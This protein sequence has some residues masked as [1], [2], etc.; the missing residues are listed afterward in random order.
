M[1][2]QAEFIVRHLISLM[3][4]AQRGN[5]ALKDAAFDALVADIKYDEAA[6]R[7]VLDRLE[8]LARELRSKPDEL[9]R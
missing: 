2:D 8:D 6:T 4:A 9:R 3:S 5:N 7:T 1:D